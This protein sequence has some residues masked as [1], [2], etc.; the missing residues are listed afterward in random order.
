MAHNNIFLVY[1]PRGQHDDLLQSLVIALMCVCVLGGGG[2]GAGGKYI[3]INTVLS[4]LWFGFWVLIFH[5]SF[6]LLFYS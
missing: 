5:H 1:C 6:K 2:G 3:A 4:C